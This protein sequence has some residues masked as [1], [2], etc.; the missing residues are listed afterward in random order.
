MWLLKDCSRGYSQDGRRCKRG[1]CNTL[2]VI[3]TTAGSS[4]NI[5]R[6]LKTTIFYTV[7]TLKKLFVKLLDTDKS[8]ARKLTQ[9]ETQVANTNAVRGGGHW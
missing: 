5:K 7:N 8:K 3:V 1:Y 6:V 2:N 9:L 4:G